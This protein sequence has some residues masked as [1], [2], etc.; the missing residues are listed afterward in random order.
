[1]FRRRRFAQYVNGPVRAGSRRNLANH[2]GV[3][4]HV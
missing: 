2:A 1:M 4:I 3:V